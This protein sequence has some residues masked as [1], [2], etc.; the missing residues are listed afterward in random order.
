MYNVRACGANVW[1][2][3]VGHTGTDFEVK[4]NCFLDIIKILNK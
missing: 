4:W 2:L 3:P 1:G